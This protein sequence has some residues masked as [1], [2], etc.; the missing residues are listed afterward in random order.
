LVAKRPLLFWT[1]KLVTS[2]T[3]GAGIAAAFHC[4]N[5]FK[6]NWLDLGKIKAI[7]QTETKF[8]QTEE[9]FGQK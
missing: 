6:Q 9:K 2:S 4:K 1:C 8:G 7:L 5:Y 3:V